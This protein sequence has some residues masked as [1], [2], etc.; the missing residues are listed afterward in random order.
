M[1]LVFF[2][3]R[4]RQFVAVCFV[5]VWGLTNHCSEK[6]WKSQKLNEG[7]LKLLQENFYDFR[8][9]YTGSKSWSTNMPPQQRLWPFSLF[10][11]TLVSISSYSWRRGDTCPDLCHLLKQWQI[12]LH[13]N[14]SPS[15]PP[16]EPQKPAR[17]S[18][19]FPAPQFWL[20]LGVLMEAVL[21]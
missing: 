13:A 18:H 4:R 15:V 2:I 10:Y 9:M 3:I 1:E 17:L 21:N 5:S 16:G 19:S 6:L 7:F 20:H 11:M 14:W 12:V 8:L